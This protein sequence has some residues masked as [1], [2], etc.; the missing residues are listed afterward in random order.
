MLDFFKN[1]AKTI[2]SRSA[3]RF[4]RLS[5]LS[6]PPNKQTI[7]LLAYLVT[8]LVVGIITYSL[9]ISGYFQATVNPPG[10][11]DGGSPRGKDAT[12]DSYITSGRVTF[13]DNTPATDLYVCF[14]SGSSSQCSPTDDGGNYIATFATPGQMFISFVKAS[15]ENV[16]Y[17]IID[18]PENNYFVFEP[19]DSFDIQIEPNP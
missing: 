16:T 5:S 8:A 3:P 19:Y 17:H 18:N 9:I 1:K 14:E 7:K 4:P 6:N 15:D 12:I 13:A 10:G 11:G 2:F